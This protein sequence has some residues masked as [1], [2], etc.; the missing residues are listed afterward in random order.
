MFEKV[1]TYLD[2]VF[3][4]E[5]N[6]KS[7][8]FSWW[9]FIGRNLREK[10]NSFEILCNEKLKWFSENNCTECTGE[11]NTQNFRQ[12]RILTDIFKRWADFAKLRDDVSIFLFQY[13]FRMAFPSALT[14]NGLCGCIK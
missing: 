14:N 8:G 10:S 1:S 12:R 5:N 9:H 6:D 2:L 4:P 11:L 13:N 3:F 7:M